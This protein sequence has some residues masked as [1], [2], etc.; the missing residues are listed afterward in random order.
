M[1]LETRLAAL[2]EK[3]TDQHPSVQNVQA[4]IQETQQRSRLRS[5]RSSRRGLGERKCS[6]GPSRRQLSKQMAAL[7][8]EIVSLQAKE[9]TLQERANRLRRSLSAMSGREQE[10]SRLCAP[11]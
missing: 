11:S 9:D 10:Y 2:T 1:Q 8:V 4:D 5:S 7:D 3:Y 6:S